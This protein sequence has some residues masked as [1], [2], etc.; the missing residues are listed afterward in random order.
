MEYIKHV[1]IVLAAV[2]INIV[3]AGAFMRFA[4][5]IGELLGLKRL[6]AFLL[7]L[8]SKKAN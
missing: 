4:D 6:I 1:L 2:F 5:Y 8:G 7:Q 3:I